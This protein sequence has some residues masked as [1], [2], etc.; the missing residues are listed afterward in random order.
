MD[1]AGFAVVLFMVQTVNMKGSLHTRV[2]VQSLPARS[3]TPPRSSLCRTVMRP[4]LFQY[5]VCKMKKSEL[6]LSQSLGRSGGS[7]P[8]IRKRVYEHSCA[9]SSV[10]FTADS[11][12][13]IHAPVFFT[14]LK[15]RASW[16]GSP[17]R[18]SARDS[19]VHRT[20]RF[21][22]STLPSRS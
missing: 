18:V 2:G 22:T 9:S 20:I 14:R 7:R 10:P 4:L 8:Y 16:T 12:I 17:A 11:C 21:R 3:T 6:H 15:R 1:V 5:R 13:V 19:S